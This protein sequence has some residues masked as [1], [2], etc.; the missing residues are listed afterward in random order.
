MNDPNF[1]TWQDNTQ[2]TEINDLSDNSVGSYGDN[3]NT[4]ST[5]FDDL[6]NPS[7]FDQHNNYLGSQTYFHEPEQNWLDNSRDYSA[8]DGLG[9]YNAHPSMPASG[10]I[11]FG[12]SDTVT[13]SDSVCKYDKSDFTE[14]ADGTLYKSTSDYT[15]GKNG[16][17]QG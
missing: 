4:V 10:T 8:I 14:A 2:L 12:S 7:F 1:D 15:N 6:G 16:Y 5:A 17:T 3:L 11:H 9:G 13:L